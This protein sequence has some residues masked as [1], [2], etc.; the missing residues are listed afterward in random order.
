MS[1]SLLTDAPA[2]D[3]QTLARLRV[4]LRLLAVGMYVA[5]I[6][7]LLSVEHYDETLQLIPFALCG[8]GILAV[9]AD[10][11]VPRLWSTWALRGVAV[12][13]AAG[14]AYGLYLHLRGNY[15]FAS[16]I[17]AHASTRYLVEA[18]LRGG[19]PLLAPGLLTVAALLALAATYGEARPVVERG[20]SRA[21]VATARRGGAVAGPGS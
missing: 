11:A 14:S 15:E 19:N 6:G 7:E 17:H 13:T 2:S 8:L 20:S 10:W 5:S 16:E 12:L 21:T 1:G 3:G 4:F 18:T 9:A